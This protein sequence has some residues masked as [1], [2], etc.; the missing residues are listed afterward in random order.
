[1]E[2]NNPT[3]GNEASFTRE[4][5]PEAGVMHHIVDHATG[6]RLDLCVALLRLFRLW[7][8]MAADERQR[9][10]HHELTTLADHG[11]C[12]FQSETWVLRRSADA[13]PMTIR[14]SKLTDLE[15]I[16]YLVFAAQ[17]VPNDRYCQWAR[18]AAAA[19]LSPAQLAVR[20]DLP[21]GW[22]LDALFT[23]LACYRRANRAVG[24]YW[25]FPLLYLCLRD[26]TSWNGG[27]SAGAVIHVAEE[28]LSTCPVPTATVRA[29]DAV[30]LPPGCA[31][32][33]HHWSRGQ[34][35]DLHPLVRYVMQYQCQVLASPVG[36]EGRE[37]T[38]CGRQDTLELDP[39][40]MNLWVLTVGGTP[41]ATA[42]VTEWPKEAGYLYV[43]SLCAHT[44]AGGGSMML[45]HLK[46]Y[47][48][49]SAGRLQSIQ[50]STWD[51]DG[52]RFYAQRGWVPDPAHP[53]G[54]EMVWHA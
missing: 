12:V 31:V 47:V 24:L 32:H 37:W 51:A 3:M 2:E 6:E 34:W 13:Q 7:S 39:Q 15:S 10:I 46:A 18:Q 26:R 44:G 19:P 9:R 45:D 1:M 14:R 16:G 29:C 35:T 52:S 21:T 28:R 40:W 36:A 4:A 53:D 22:S 49:A 54:R 11:L 43:D 20:P 42:A 8:G 41:L 33:M 17:P 50:L 27:T 25:M 30:H 38:S 23:L 5:G 48:H